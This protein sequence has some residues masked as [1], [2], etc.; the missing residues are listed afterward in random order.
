MTVLVCRRPDAIHV[1]LVVTVLVANWCGGPFAIVWLSGSRHLRFWN[2]IVQGVPVLAVI[3]PPVNVISGVPDDPKD[4]ETA[5]TG[6]GFAG[7]I[8]CG[9]VRAYSRDFLR[10]FRVAGSGLVS[11]TGLPA[12]NIVRTMASRRCIAVPSGRLGMTVLGLTES[13]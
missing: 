12:A 4:D 6:P 9:H 7:S 3:G 1:H 11:D 5:N 10:R 2:V 13:S 8:L